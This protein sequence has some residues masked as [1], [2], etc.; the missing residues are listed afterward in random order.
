MQTD[1]GIELSKVWYL[2]NTL[3]L[4]ATIPAF[5]QYWEFRIPGQSSTC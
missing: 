2:V 5:L 4:N 3:M 1:C